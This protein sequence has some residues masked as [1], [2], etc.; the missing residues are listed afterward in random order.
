MEKTIQ[1][2]GMMCPHCEARV[3]KLLVE[4]DGVASANVSH[5][6]GTAIVTLNAPVEDAVFEK[7][8]TDNG[9]KV[10]AITSK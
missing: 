3:K 7:A 10:I 2:E 5:V 8:I 6:D 4:M 1:I 9:Y